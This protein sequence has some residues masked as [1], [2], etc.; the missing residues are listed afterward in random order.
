MPAR[1][2][3]ICFAI[4]HCLQLTFHIQMAF[5]ASSIHILFS[6]SGNS[7]TRTSLGSMQHLNIYRRTTGERKFLPPTRN[8]RPPP[9][10]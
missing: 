7:V 3:S 1:A 4:Y 9:I 10:S 2:L 6:L 5:R 8:S